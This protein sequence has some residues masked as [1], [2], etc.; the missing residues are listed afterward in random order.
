ME[1]LKNSPFSMTFNNKC[2]MQESTLDTKIHGCDIRLF[3]SLKALPHKINTYKHI[4][5]ILVKNLAGNT[6]TNGSIFINGTNRHYVPP[7][8]IS[9]E[10]H[11]TITLGFLPKVLNLFIVRKHQQ[12]QN[13]RHSTK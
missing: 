9:W 13:E 8:M 2:L 6:L 10:E 12:T 5:V 3:S 4:I 1:L 11:N 7:D